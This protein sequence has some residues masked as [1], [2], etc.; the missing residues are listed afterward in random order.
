MTYQSRLL[1]ER[2]ARQRALE[3]SGRPGTEMDPRT[4]RAI[5]ADLAAGQ[6]LAPGLEVDTRGRQALR[7]DASIRTNQRSQFQVNADAL[8]F[9]DPSE[10]SQAATKAYVDK[11]IGLAGTAV[12][13]QTD[14][15]Y[16]TL[17]N[18]TGGLLVIPCIGA[19][20]L[21]ELEIDAGNLLSQGTNGI[22]MKGGHTYIVRASLSVMS[23][24]SSSYHQGLLGIG[25]SNSGGT[26]IPLWRTTRANGSQRT[27]WTVESA[28]EATEDTEALIIYLWQT[29]N[30][31]FRLAFPQLTVQR[32]QPYVDPGE[33]APLP[34]LYSIVAEFRSDTVTAAPRGNINFYDQSY[35]D[36][37]TAWSWT[38]G[39]G[40]TSTLQNPA[41]QYAT[42]GTYTV[43]L[44]VTGSSGNDTET[45]TSYITVT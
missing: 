5:E 17:Y 44:T 33:T 27:L 13:S 45:K 28:Y 42:A 35:N 20:N 19:T 4:R 31:Q 26:I 38:F 37:A 2:A 15:D 40:T 22:D 9:A 43:S 10:S 11:Q 21:E 12:R 7:H 18:A 1:R 14:L 3:L 25:Y 36:T 23:N 6:R 34:G 39:D 41:K 32:V 30:L 16:N 24:S 8:R 29:E